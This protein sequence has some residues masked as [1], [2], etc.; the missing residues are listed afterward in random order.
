MFV[1]LFLFFFSPLQL[2]ESNNNEPLP[3]Y[4][5]IIDPENF[6]RTI[7]NAFQVSFLLRDGAVALEEDEDGYPTVRPIL[8]SGKADFED[9]NHQMVSNLTTKMCDVICV[10]VILANWRLI[11]ID[12]FHFFH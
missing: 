2:Y 5:L 9:R 10:V 7:H 8:D 11:L 6:M 12:C 3:Y 4:Q 1:F